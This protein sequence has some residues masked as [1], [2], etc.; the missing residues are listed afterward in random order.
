MQN[1]HDGE[2][3]EDRGGPRDC[4]NYLS[5]PGDGPVFQA[6]VKVWPWKTPGGHEQGNRMYVPGCFVEALFADAPVPEPEELTPV[7]FLV[8]CLSW[9]YASAGLV[10]LMEEGAHHHHHPLP[11]CHIYPCLCKSQTLI[12]RYTSHLRDQ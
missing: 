8:K 2:Y 6:T 1:A 7:K 9:D 11:T 5:F 10:K 12:F 4:H 3:D